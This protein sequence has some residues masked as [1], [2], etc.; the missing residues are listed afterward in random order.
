MS[1]YKKASDALALDASTDAAATTYTEDSPA[2]LLD[3]FGV[4]ELP[5]G[6]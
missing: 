4:R 3:A 6:S 5:R 1:N 2:P